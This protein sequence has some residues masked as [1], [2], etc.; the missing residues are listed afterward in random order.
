M[1]LTAPQGLFRSLL[2]SVYLSF[3]LKK[4]TSRGFPEMNEAPTDGLEGARRVLRGTLVRSPIL[5]RI[6][7]AFHFATFLRRLINRINL[8]RPARSNH[9]EARTFVF[10]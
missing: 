4:A 10:R 8:D 5:S 9:L 1:S 7:D 6:M 3:N 2:K